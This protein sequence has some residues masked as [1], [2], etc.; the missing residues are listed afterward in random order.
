MAGALPGALL[1][2]ALVYGGIRCTGVYG[3]R[4]PGSWGHIARCCSLLLTAAADTSGQPSVTELQVT[5]YS[6]KDSGYSLPVRLNA[7]TAVL[8]TATATQRILCVAAATTEYGILPVRVQTWDI[9]YCLL[10]K[11][12]PKFVGQ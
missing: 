11:L 10:N 8:H 5:G 2:C 3:I 4:G 9:A 1:L 6:F 12:L 7:T